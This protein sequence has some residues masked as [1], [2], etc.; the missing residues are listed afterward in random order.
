MF[1]RGFFPGPIPS[2]FRVDFIEILEDHTTKSYRAEFSKDRKAHEAESSL[3]RKYG[4]FSAI[5]SHLDNNWAIWVAENVECIPLF[6]IFGRP[7]SNS[8]F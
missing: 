7:K 8:V 4:Y 5:F 2:S 6:C 1:P 3:D